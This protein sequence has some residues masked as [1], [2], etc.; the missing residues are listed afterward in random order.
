MTPRTTRR[1]RRKVMDDDRGAAAITGAFVIAAIV[2][3]AALV[4]HMSAAVAARHRARAVADLAAISAATALDRGEGA[5]CEVSDRVADRMAARVE[6][7]QAIGWDVRVAVSVPVSLGPLGH[8]VARAEAQA[9]PRA[10][11]S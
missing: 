5:A 4:L 6:H 8:R 1:P 7:C 3:V 9:G 11:G 10:D 2:I